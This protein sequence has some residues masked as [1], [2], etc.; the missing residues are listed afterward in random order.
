MC[1]TS[2][3][4]LTFYSYT[5][6]IEN[7]FWELKLRR[8]TLW[9]LNSFTKEQYS[10]HLQGVN[11]INPV[12]GLVQGANLICFKALP[13]GTSIRFALLRLLALCY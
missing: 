11:D 6:V 2:Y 9:S 12:V 4:T 3:E 8:E 5:C 1:L 13:V 7:V 10:C